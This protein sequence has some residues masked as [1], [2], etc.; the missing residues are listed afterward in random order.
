MNSPQARKKSVGHIANLKALPRVNFALGLVVV[1]AVIALGFWLVQTFAATSA[2]MPLGASASCG[3]RVSTYNYKRMYA[4]TMPWNVPVCGLKKYAYSDDYRDRLFNYGIAPKAGNA[5]EVSQQEAMKGK[6]G[7]MF[8]LNP[9][10][11]YST[12]VYR[13]SD[14]VNGA[15]TT[16]KIQVCGGQPQCIAS[17]LDSIDYNVQYGQGK[18]FLPD[19]PLPWNPTWLPA[20]SNDKE[21]AI[22]DDRDPNYPKEYGAWGVFLDPGEAF[23]QCGLDSFSFQRTRLCTWTAGVTKEKNGTI[24][25]MNTSTVLSGGR[26]MGIQGTPMVITPEEVAQGEIRSALYMEAYN[27]M[28]G[29]SCTAAQMATNDYTNVI[30]KTCGFAVAPA[31]QHEWKNATDIGRANG[32]GATPNCAGAAAATDY[33][34]GKTMAER[35]RLPQEIPSGMRF[36]ITNTDAEI[37]AWLNTKNY[38][39][40]KRQT[41]KIIA[42]ALRDYGWFV[43]DTT[44]DSAI[45][46][47]AGVRNPETKKKWAKLG[48]DDVSSES[49]LDG[50][51]ERTKMYAV[52]PS[53]NQ[54]VD[55]TAS[56]FACEAITS[57]YPNIAN[58]QSTPTPTVKPSVTTTPSL[59]PTPTPKPTVAPTLTPTPTPK[60][61]VTPAP[62]PVPSV[63]KIAPTAPTSIRPNLIYDFLKGHYYVLLEWNDAKD[64]RAGA[65]KY[66]VK[67]NNVNV[68][69]VSQTTKAFA[70]YGIKADT[71]Y[72][73]QVNAID[74]AGN[75]STSPVQSNFTIRCFWIF[76]GIQ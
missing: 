18:G 68:T 30:G 26:G 67:R 55:G 45:L 69:P 35:V 51:F 34:T 38:S 59:T 37:D 65:L 21:I 13:T 75:V 63:D 48:I 14:P 22:I 54:C 62:T 64:D 60:P 46:S 19:T 50:L 36:A 9:N 23:V 40:A 49:L 43:G 72:N 66:S 7:T 12:P 20:L 58:T 10:N 5:Y 33:R 16:I 57:L 24:A 56:N 44:C 74:A 71:L 25:N 1:L 29:P 28:T 8:G 70:D 6:F 2:D 42:V 17:N 31:T 53:Q 32:P 41:A 73:Y 27:T 52:E 61:T 76:C 11:D 3:A 39:P 15:T 47:F 4:K